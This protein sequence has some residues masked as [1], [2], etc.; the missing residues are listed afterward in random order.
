MLMCKPARIQARIRKHARTN[1]S[2]EISYL[3]KQ[4]HQRGLDTVK[5]IIEVCCECARVCVGVCRSLELKFDTV[6]W[7]MRR[8]ICPGTATR[9]QCT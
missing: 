6:L 4:L 5:L 9:T 1:A 8:C 7:I 3:R 2:D